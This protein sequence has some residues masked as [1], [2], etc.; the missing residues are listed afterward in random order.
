MTRGLRPA[1]QASVIRYSA[2]R[3]CPESAS[4]GPRRRPPIA[5]AD[6]PVPASRSRGRS[7]PPSAIR[8]ALA[9]LKFHS[10]IR[11]ARHRPARPVAAER[12]GREEGQGQE[13]KAVVGEKRGQRG[14]KGRGEIQ[15]E[16]D[17]RKNVREV[18]VPMVGEHRLD[19]GEGG[20]LVGGRRA[21]PPGR[22]MN[23]QVA[24][25]RRGRPVARPAFSSGRR[26]SQA[27]SPEPATSYAAR[28]RR[29]Q[30]V[31]AG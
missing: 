28:R 10:G 20:R 19:G 1:V 7:T 29:R 13:P 9:A 17:I 11:S 30:Q 16:N 27:E 24:W 26:A 25:L 23:F 3:G 18:E 14:E 5:G 4:P 31:R 21:T 2:G 12:S 8:S 6:P 15:R 22:H